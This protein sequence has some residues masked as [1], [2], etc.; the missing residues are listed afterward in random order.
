MKR[1][2]DWYNTEQSLELQ[3]T[4]DSVKHLAG[5]FLDLGVWQGWSTIIIANIIEPKIVT[6]VDWWR[7]NIIED[8]NHVTVQILKERDVYSEFLE[9]IKTD[10]SGNVEVVKG[11]IIEYLERLEQKVAFAHIDASHEYES[12]DKTIKLLLPQI[13]TG[14]TICGDD[15][16]NANAGRIDLRG[17]V[18]R[19]VRENLPD[20][21]QIDNFWR[22]R[23]Q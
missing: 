16:K 19:A 6:A 8:P 13:V 2:E 11:D 23:K 4:V 10:T 18:E 20:F 17:G 3:K 21:E 5:L 15:F 7:G 14:G 9:N 1:D 22:W 12:V